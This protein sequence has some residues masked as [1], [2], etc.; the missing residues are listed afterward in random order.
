MTKRELQTE[1]RLAALEGKGTPVD[2]VRCLMCNGTG[3]YDQYDL[4]DR[5]GRRNT[6]C[7]RCGRRGWLHRAEL[8]PYPPRRS[9]KRQWGQGMRD[10]PRE[11]LGVAFLVVIG[12]L[13]YTLS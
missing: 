1:A 4:R 3:Q 9:Q 2:A 7:P 6:D 11:Y 13:L 5:N 8:Y 12:L 10:T